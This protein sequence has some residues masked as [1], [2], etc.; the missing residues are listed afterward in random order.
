MQYLLS[1]HAR[2]IPPFAW[3]EGAFTDQE[4]NW[5]QNLAKRAEQN[6]Q[7]GSDVGG[8]VNNNVRRSQVSWLENNSNSKFVFEKLAD[9]TNQL[10]SK[11]FGFDLTGFG[12]AI[13]LTNYDQ[14]EHGMY[15][16]HQ[17]YNNKNI[18]RKLSLVVQ[19]SDPSEYE[20]GNLQIMTTG[21]PDNVRKQRG[22]VAVFPSYVLHQVTPVTQGSRQSLVAWVSGP[23]FK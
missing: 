2:E 23:A 19:L 12:E 17:D 8:V 1:P 14:S 16:W 13:Q 6:A 20:G 7:V 4:L 10:N 11:H 5:L 18:S 9:I 22:L 15:G 3:W 21:Q